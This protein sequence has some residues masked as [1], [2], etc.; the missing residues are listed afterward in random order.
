MYEQITF[1]D[2]ANP[3]KIDKPVRLI[4]LFAGIGSQAAALRNIGVD[5][6]HYRICEY[7]KQAITSYNAI[8]GTS[9]VESDITNI[10]AGDLNITDTENYTYIL[11]YSF[12][13]QDLTIAGNRKGMKKGTRSGL[14]WEVERILKECE[15]LPQILVMENV[16]N[17]TSAQNAEDFLRWIYRLEE[18]GYRNKY[19]LMNARDY[20]MPQ[21]RE[22][23]IMVS[24]LGDFYY[25][26]P[27]PFSLENKA[28]DY[29]DNSKELIKS[30]SAS[31]QLIVYSDKTKAHIKQSTKKGYADL[32]NYGVAA[33]SYP[34]SETRRGRVIKNGNVCPTITCSTQ[35]LYKFIDGEFYRLSP[36]ECWRLMGFRDEDFYKA[37]SAGVSE[38]QLYKQAGN[39][40]V[41]NVLEEVFKKMI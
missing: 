6:E 19:E 20:K 2:G 40:I 39:S 34:T 27:A 8:H 36:L 22:R 12:P 31:K 11:T 38:N 5:F 4:E 10:K 9:F 23:C 18:L 14:L 25:D 37:K 16:P 3:L 35:E 32:I 41:V 17:I 28:S 30:E 13:C 21:N 29:F 15:E 26:F 33:F 7:D 1:F 24:Y